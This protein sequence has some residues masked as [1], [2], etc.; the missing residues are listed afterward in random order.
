MG[1]TTQG[2]VMQYENQFGPQVSHQKTVIS[3]PKEK[4]AKTRDSETTVQDEEK[5]GFVPDEGISIVEFRAKS[6]SLKRHIQGKWLLQNQS[7]IPSS[8]LKC[9]TG[10]SLQ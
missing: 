5:N 8:H 6:R 9:P 7:D 1:K 2:I 3:N 4:I 10:R